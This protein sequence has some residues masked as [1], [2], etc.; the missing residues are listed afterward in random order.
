MYERFTDRARLV[1]KLANQEALRLN[2]ACI[3]TEQI[4]HGLIEEGAG[5]A[6]QVLRN[7]HVDAN[8]VR[9]E[10]EKI[11]KP[12][13]DKLKTRMR[14]RTPGAMNVIRYAMEESRNLQHNYVGTEHILLGL[15]R[16]QEGTAAQIL[17]NFGL[18]LDNVRQEILTM[19]VVHRVVTVQT[20][21]QRKIVGCL[22]LLNLVLLI[23]W[24]VSSRAH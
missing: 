12:G 20:P 4:L 16:E 7:L 13:P 3:G 9:V 21:L 18:S 23:Y 15:I 2:V 6:A 1:M 17:I 8:Q 22:L 11:V 10:V 14:P 19:L 24:I 5:V